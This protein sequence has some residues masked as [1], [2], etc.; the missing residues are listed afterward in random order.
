MDLP[1]P[2]HPQKL[3]WLLSGQA[4]PLAGLPLE[5]AGRVQT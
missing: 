4:R 2:I 1:K 5:S 3:A